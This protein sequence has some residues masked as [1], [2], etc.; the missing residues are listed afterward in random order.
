MHLG[1]AS[2]FDASLPPRQVLH[3]KRIV[4]G[5]GDD[6]LVER[7]EPLSQFSAGSG[8]KGLGS[9]FQ[10]ASHMVV[11]TGHVWVVV[12]VVKGWVSARTVAGPCPS[13]ERVGDGAWVKAVAALE[14]SDLTVG[15]RR[16]TRMTG[17][18]RRIAVSR[19]RG[20]RLG[21][22]DLISP[23]D[24][25]GKSTSRERVLDVP[26]SKRAGRRPAAF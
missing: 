24:R 1:H 10:E 3:D 5:A 7:I 26:D 21:S 18:R 15:R 16:G 6:L 14:V 23:G 9:S 12:P 4:D 13:R 25:R 11:A 17:G 2:D 22:C 8:A 20:K 19:P